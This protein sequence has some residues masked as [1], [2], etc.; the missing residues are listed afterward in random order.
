[1]ESGALVADVV[2]GSPAEQAGILRGDVIVDFNNEKVEE[3][4]NLRNT[5]ASTHPGD[6]VDMTVIRNG[7]YETLTVIIGELP[8]ESQAPQS[9]AAYNNALKGVSVQ[10]LTP[11]IYKQLDTLYGPF[12]DGIHGA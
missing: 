1:M 4:Y 5:V 12:G 2:E 3:P 10:E 8:G 11:D 9:K 6:S 7:K